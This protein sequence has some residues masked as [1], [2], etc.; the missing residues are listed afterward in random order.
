M[1]NPEECTTS[2]PGREGAFHLLPI[3]RR[4]ILRARPSTTLDCREVYGKDLPQNV[5]SRSTDAA[6][7]MRSGVLCLG[8]LQPGGGTLWAIRQ[9]RKRGSRG[10]A[11]V[12]VTRTSREKP[13]FRKS[14]SWFFFLV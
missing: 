13:A 5:W 10:S 14:C 11:R 9:R 1:T 7:E 4:P 3:R 8:R 2:S 6:Q 12:D